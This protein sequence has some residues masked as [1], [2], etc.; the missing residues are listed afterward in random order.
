MWHT[1]ELIDRKTGVPHLLFNFARRNVQF[2]R[3]YKI[4]PNLDLS[5]LDKPKLSHI[6]KAAPMGR[7]FPTQNYEKAITFIFRQ[8]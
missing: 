1:F 6:K 3:S 4:N 2:G 8:F 5:L 7:P